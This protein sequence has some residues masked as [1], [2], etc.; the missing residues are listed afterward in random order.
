MYNPILVNKNNANDEDD[1][2]L[3]RQ[4]AAKRFKS[5][6]QSLSKQK[7]ADNG[8]PLQQMHAEQLLFMQQQLQQHQNEL[9]LQQ[10]REEATHQNKDMLSMINQIMMA[11]AA[12]NSLNRGQ[13]NNDNENDEDADDESN[14]SPDQIVNSHGDDFN[15]DGY[16]E[17]EIYNKNQLVSINNRAHV[18]QNKLR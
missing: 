4:Q 9:E 7:P 12:A 17:D 1:C 13:V 16:N 11:A 10:Q 6:E 3:E 5:S 15:T 2:I 8:A 14:S 18:A